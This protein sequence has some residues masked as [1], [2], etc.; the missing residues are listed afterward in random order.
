MK[1]IKK[2]ES[3]KPIDW[4]NASQIKDTLFTDDEFS[5]IKYLYIDLIE[6]L[7]LTSVEI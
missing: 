2:F 7:N 1:F 4:S 3:H 6:D 5:D